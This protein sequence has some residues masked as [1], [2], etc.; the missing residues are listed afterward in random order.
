MPV[1]FHKNQLTHK[2]LLQEHAKKYM[3]LTTK[4]GTFLVLAY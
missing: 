1:E 4:V 3:D 2:P